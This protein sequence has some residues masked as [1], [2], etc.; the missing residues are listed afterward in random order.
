VLSPVATK[1]R[2]GEEEEL[3]DLDAPPPL[4]SAHQQASFQTQSTPP[5][6]RPATQ[7]FAASRYDTSAEPKRSSD[8]HSEENLKVRVSLWHILVYFRMKYTYMHAH[9]NIQAHTHI[10]THTHT[11]RYTLTHAHTHTH[12]H[13]QARTSPDTHTY[14]LTHTL[15]C[16]CRH[17]LIQM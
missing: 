8:S 12:R 1:A 13:I 5:L 7:A 3:L 16:I 9:K 17:K 2:E 15:A 10:S 4:P 14:T 11:H 6:Q